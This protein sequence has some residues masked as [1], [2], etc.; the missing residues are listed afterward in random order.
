MILLDL[1]RAEP[2][3]VAE[4]GEPDPFTDVS[5][6]VAT[7]FRPSVYIEKTQAWLFLD[8]TRFGNFILR[9]VAQNTGS[10]VEQTRLGIF[11]P[12]SR[13]DLILLKQLLKNEELEEN[14][15]D[16]E[17]LCASFDGQS[18]LHE[19]SEAK[20]LHGLKSVFDFISNL[21]L[22]SGRDLDDLKFYETT[23]RRL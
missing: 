12:H 17:L 6:Y 14:Y 19:L 22:N 10:S 15:V 16:A 5:N 21:E 11:E 18:I 3:P 2:T 1:N 20:S 9:S 4:L 8:Q 13:Y 7:P 23:L